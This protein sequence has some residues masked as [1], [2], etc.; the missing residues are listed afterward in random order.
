MATIE[1]PSFDFSAFYY[2][3]LYRALI[4]F[5]RRNAPELTDE[6]DQE[7]SIQLLKAFALVGHL[8]NTFLDMVANEC[9][10]RTARLAETI[11]GQLR[12]IDYRLNP[13]VPSQVELI[14]R[15]NRL[16]G[17][18]T[19]V[20]PFGAQ[21][22][23]ERGESEE[24]VIF[25][26]TNESVTV[27]P[28]DQ[29]GH[30]ILK[31][32]SGTIIDYTEQ[33]V[34]ES[35]SI[36]IVWSGGVELYFGHPSVMFSGIEFGSS[37]GNPDVGIWEYYDGSTD[38]GAPDDVENKGGYLR[39]HVDGILGSSNRSGTV[40]RV[41]LNSTGAYED[42]VVSWAG[43][44]AIETESILGQSIISLDPNDYTVGTEW[45]ELPNVSS[46][47][48]AEEGNSITWDLPQ[49]ENYNW[50][51][52]AL[53]EG[54]IEGYF[55]RYRAIYV[56]EE[57]NGEYS[58][59]SLM[60]PHYILANAV[61]GKTVFAETIGSS[62]GLPDQSFLLQQTGFIWG[63][64]SIRIDE[65]TWERVDDFLNSGSTDKHYVLDLEQDDRA[66]IFFGNGSNG[67]IPP[68]GQGNIVGDYR[69]NAQDNGNVGAKTIVVDKAGLT[70]VDQ[71][72]NPRPAVGWA[73]SEAS[74]PDTL[75]AAKILGPA[76]LRAKEV[77]I[78]PDDLE[79]L[80]VRFQSDDGT[81]PFGRVRPFEE[82]LGPKTVEL[83]C[84]AR[85]GGIPTDA[86]LAALEDYFNGDKLSSPPKPKRIITNNKVHC[87][88]YERRLIN[89]EAIV[90]GPSD[91]AADQIKNH[92]ATI[93]Q[94]ERK[95]KDGSHWMWSFGG[96]VPFSLIY[97][98]IHEV[99]PRI[100]KVVL[101]SP[102]FDIQ[103]GERELPYPGN[104]SIKVI[105]VK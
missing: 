34:S 59:I 29:I 62:N 83:V 78:S 30:V 50:K 52:Y 87:T 86:Q 18:T 31:N 61:Q 56:E 6:S 48:I 26:E 25:F 101:N 81:S 89:V 41:K 8:N 68:I 73:A 13:A 19:E 35:D 75:E 5:K 27:E 84:V 72:F 64:E 36:A 58:L 21:A 85:G 4:E 40:V 7:I 1:V 82:G 20:V 76:S 15:L 44:N 95:T 11:R 12:L 71:I 43:S 53:D 67:M 79:T 92:L 45:K 33:A 32:A 23:T 98:E 10:L 65:E 37:E 104:L 57:T 28:T 63:S 66:R 38:D 93:L 60:R 105:P 39:F 91:L 49:T 2:A 17:A 42:C 96:T 70:F 46:E 54:S 9:T 22:A 69:C 77:A 102:S 14:Y 51:K 16:F 100:Q 24:P 94:P 88:T 97:H 90:Y 99:D 47:F 80:A 74:N 3:Q 103:L 55:V